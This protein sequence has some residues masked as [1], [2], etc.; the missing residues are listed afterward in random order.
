[1]TN[2]PMLCAQ[3]LVDPPGGQD[4]VRAARTAVAGTLLC[5]PH[6]VTA[7]QTQRDVGAFVS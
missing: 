4:S 7:L 3:C 1:M 2:E 5:I 6:A